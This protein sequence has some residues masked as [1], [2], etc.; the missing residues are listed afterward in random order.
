MSFAPSRRVLLAGLTIIPTTLAALC[1]A[2]AAF[3]SDPLGTQLSIAQR[4]A[5]QYV[6][7]QIRNAPSDEADT[8]PGGIAPVTPA[9]TPTS[10]SFSNAAIVEASG[11]ERSRTLDGAYWVHNDSGGLA[12]VFA[13]DA[14]GSDF[15]RVLLDGVR[16]RDWEDIAGTT[17]D[18]VPHLVVGD[19]GDNKEAR[20][21]YYVHV[22]EEPDLSCLQPD[23]DL[24]ITD[25]TTLALSYDDGSSHNAE[26][27]AID[28]VTGEFL[29]VTKTNTDF[30][31]QALWTG[32][33]AEAMTTGE[34]VLSRKASMDGLV[35][36]LGG[37]L[38]V[39]GMDV[40]S[41]GSQ[42]SLLVYGRFYMGR[43]LGWDAAP[44][45]TWTD[46]LSGAPDHD[47]DVPL[48]RDNIQAEGLT[49]DRDG[50]RVLIVAEAAPASPS[51]VTSIDAPATANVQVTPTA[52]PSPSPP[53][54]PSTDEAGD[55]IT[56]GR[57]VALTVL[58][59]L[60]VGLVV[61]AVRR[62]SRG[63]R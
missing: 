34:L 39:T 61:F 44:G 16:P 33:L 8:C 12:D 36:E 1:S 5:S 59:I 11:I 41:D 9:T 55:L 32:S 26:S 48:L 14:A 50:A 18:G 35:D 58:T 62:T 31:T 24:V 43:V 37:S 47:V 7:G 46:I 23:F 28:P 10:T 3:S 6:A 63:N 57:G 60:L 15:G 4:G 25:F 21:G 17:I 38:S 45:K 49:Y 54:A 19:V 27:T 53:S 42:L 40:A 13:T 29:L 22:F 51:A 56:T 30:T 2:S 20:T 52:E